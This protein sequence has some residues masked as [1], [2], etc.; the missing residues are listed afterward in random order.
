MDL[1]AKALDGYLKRL[2][3]VQQQV[4]AITGAVGEAARALP[5]CAMRTEIPSKR[6][7]KNSPPLSILARST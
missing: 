6:F 4:P 2:K 5:C 3:R 1:D 7:V